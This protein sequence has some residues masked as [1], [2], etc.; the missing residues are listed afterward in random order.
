[1][2]VL[3]LILLSLF[4]LIT[5][6]ETAVEDCRAE[7]LRNLSDQASYKKATLQLDTFGPSQ[8]DDNYKNPSVTIWY[9]A[10]AV[11]EDGQVHT[12]KTLLQ[13][14]REN[15]K[16]C[17]DVQ[18]DSLSN[19]PMKKAYVECIEIAS[20]NLRRILK[21]KG[22]EMKESSLSVVKTSQL[23]SLTELLVFKAEG[24][25]KTGNIKSASYKIERSL[26]AADS[27]SAI[28]K[29]PPATAPQTQKQSGS[30]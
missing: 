2:N 1:M 12:L 26:F 20:T 24:S 13:R 5:V 23:F 6:A 15:I 3:V 28:E 22:V 27:C 25:D 16:K 19:Y 9:T 18:P 29:N 11:G 21:S 30:R 4:P 7:A 8:F 10:R 14:S 17:K